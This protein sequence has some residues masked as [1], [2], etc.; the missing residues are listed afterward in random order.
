MGTILVSIEPVSPTT[1]DKLIKPARPSLHTISH[2]GCVVHWSSDQP[3][4]ILHPSFADFLTD[5]ERCTVAK[6][7]I[8]LPS[9]HRRLVHQCLKY[10][11][12]KLRENVLGKKRDCNGRFYDYSTPECLAYASTY[13]IEHLCRV[14]DDD[15]AI[16]VGEVDQFLKQHLLHWFEVMSTVNRI[17]KTVHLLEMLQEWLKVSLSSLNELCR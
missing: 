8:D 14:T 4:R 15:V 6:W 7:H 2:L 10:L 3:L 11:N 12:E 17:I 9:H 16:L 13:W 1:I 5:H